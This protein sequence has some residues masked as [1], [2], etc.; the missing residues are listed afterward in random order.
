M[1][2]P[3]TD[4]TYGTFQW[5]SLGVSA[6]LGYTE[7][8]AGLSEPQQKRVNFLVQRGIQ[9]F[10]NPPTAPNQQKPHVW[11][12]L[13]VNATLALTNTDYD[14]DL[15]ATFGTIIGEFAFSVAAAKRRCEMIEEDR[16]RTLQSKNDQS[17]VPFYFAIRPKAVALTAEQAWEVLFYPTPN[18]SMTATYRYRTS[19]AVLDTTNLHPLGT[20]VHAETILASCLAVAEMWQSKKRDVCH[21]HFLDRLAASIQIDLLSSPATQEEELHI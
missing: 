16:L 1:S 19:H 12:F 3:V 9:Q 20:R 21:A 15:P 11:S 5:L 2:W 6:Y 14:Y 4:P 8:D 13:F 7:D 10:Y 18:A 17:G